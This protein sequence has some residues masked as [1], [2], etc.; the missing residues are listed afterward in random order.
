MEFWKWTSSP[1]LWLGLHMLFS[2]ETF[3]LQ[4]LFYPKKKKKSSRLKGPSLNMA[5]SAFHIYPYLH[6]SDVTNAQTKAREMGGPEQ[7]R[8]C[9]GIIKGTL[10]QTD[11]Q[12][13][14]P[15][16]LHVAHASRNKAGK[17]TFLYSAIVFCP[18]LRLT[19][20]QTHMKQ[21][22]VCF[23]CSSVPLC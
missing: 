12:V 14:Q 20:T 22:K 6:I 8:H 2:F 11:T 9:A 5:T 13:V 17:N 21:P 1:F 19:Q 15:F 18:N 7:D 4:V 10:T 3:V 16:S 23:H